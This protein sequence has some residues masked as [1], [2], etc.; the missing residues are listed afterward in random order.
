[1]A[2]CRRSYVHPAVLDA[3]LDGSLL[4]RLKSDVDLVLRTDLPG[5][6]PEEAA[7]LAFLRQRLGHETAAGPD[8]AAS[9]SS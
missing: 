8:Q 5:L 6:S 7:V 2:V 3:Y 1:M 9:A 4:E